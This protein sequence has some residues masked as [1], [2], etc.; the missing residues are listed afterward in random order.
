MELKM[1]F[2]PC[3]ARGHRYLAVGTRL[4]PLDQGGNAQEPPTTV[5]SV[6]ARR[7]LCAFLSSL[8]AQ[9][10]PMAPR[11]LQ[12]SFSRSKLFLIYLLGVLCL[13]TSPL[14]HAVWSCPWVLSQFNVSACEVFRDPLG[15]PQ[16]HEFQPF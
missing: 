8:S 4:S 11:H 7:D 10:S 16:T 6:Q 14:V 9:E 15:H 3:L 13:P 12:A 1:P 5:L 2:A